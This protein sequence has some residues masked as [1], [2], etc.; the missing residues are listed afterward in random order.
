MSVFPYALKNRL[1]GPADIHTPFTLLSDV[2]GFE[3]WLDD[4]SLWPMRAEGVLEKLLA[5]LAPVTER[6]KR[7]RMENAESVEL[8]RQVGGST[9]LSL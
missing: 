5:F 2:E 1:E 8:L 9:F 3:R 6:P 7:R 4:E